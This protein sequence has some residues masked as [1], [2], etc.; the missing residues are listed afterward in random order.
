MTYNLIARWSCWTEACHHNRPFLEE[1]ECCD[2]SC[3][4][5][6][7]PTQFSPGLL[8]HSGRSMTFCIFHEMG[9]WKNDLVIFEAGATYFDLSSLLS[10]ETMLNLTW[11]EYDTALDLYSV[12]C[13][14]G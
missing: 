9:M 3:L 7:S 6:L 14:T 12:L 4:R 1:S 13:L 10:E 11:E 5:K 8:S 2:T